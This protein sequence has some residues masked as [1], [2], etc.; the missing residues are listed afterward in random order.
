MESVFEAAN[1]VEAHMVLHLLQQQGVT[2]RVDGEYL[3]GAVGQL[4]ATGLVRVVVDEADADRARAIVAAFEAAQ[5]AEPAARVTPRPPSRLLWAG[6]GLVAGMLATAA[7][8]RTPASQSGIDY[9]RD[10]VL[11]EHWIYGPTGRTLRIE[12]D[13]NL[14]HRVDQ[15]IHYDERGLAASEELD[16]DFDGRFETRTFIRA[17]NVERSEVDTDGDGYADLR[18]SFRDGVLDSS[19]T[20]NPSTGLALRIEHYRLG[21][22]MEAEVDTDRD[23]RLDTRLRYDRLG[24]VAAREPLP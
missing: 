13:R 4:P 17:G 7:L 14:D 6:A 5:P 9:D 12:A 8:L 24:E 21:Q 23:G 19:S 20:M 11:D 3:Q 22:L 16:D 18:S 1:S 2:G 15:V 10:G